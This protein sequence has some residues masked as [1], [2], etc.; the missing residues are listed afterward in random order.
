[1]VK[2]FSESFLK[3]SWLLPAIGATARIGSAL[4]GGAKAVGANMAAGAAMNAG[5]K[6]MGSG[7]KPAVSNKANAMPQ[8]GKSTA[9]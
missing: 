9:F 3:T 8:T 5:S 4:A 2:S 6:L 7:T 1:M